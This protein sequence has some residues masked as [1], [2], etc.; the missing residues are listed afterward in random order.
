MRGARFA[1]A[2]C[3]AA[4]KDATLALHRA[5]A[6]GLDVRIALN[7][8]DARTDRVAFHGTRRA[9]VEEHARALGLDPLLAPVEEGQFEQTFL[10]LLDEVAVRGADGVIFGN[11]HLA[12]VRAWYEE[13]VTA[14]GLEHVEPLWGGAP[15]ELA[16]EVVDLGY[17]AIVVSVDLE[18]GDG[19]WLGRAVDS[20]LVAEIE[21]HGAD[22]CGERGE[23]HTFVWDGPGFVRPVACRLGRMVSEKTH[24]LVDLLPAAA[25]TSSAGTHAGT[26]LPRQLRQRHEP[27]ASGGQLG[28]ETPERRPARRAP[29][30]LDVQEDDGAGT[31]ALQPTP[32]VAA[33][34]RR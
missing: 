31:D 3:T 9:L 32:H 1:Y 26:V 21:S 25:G 30:D 7:L 28:E 23:Y 24:R 13:R 33:P 5:R 34:P 14:A 20:E 18:Q 6:D 27:V 10:A 16:R 19:S 29:R 15:G 12:D 22:A 4:G 11:I 2:L 8:Y 17:R